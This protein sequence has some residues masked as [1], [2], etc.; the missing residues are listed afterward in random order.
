M[1]VTKADA[2]WSKVSTKFS[3]CKQYREN[4]NALKKDEILDWTGRKF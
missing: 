3:M 1:T 2:L 4:G